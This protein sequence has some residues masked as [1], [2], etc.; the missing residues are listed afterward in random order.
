MVK[1][2]LYFTISC[3]LSF[4]NSFAQEQDS[5]EYVGVS[6][7]EYM[8]V[9]KGNLNEFI[10]NSIRY[11]ELAK[12]D[13]VQGTVVV[14]YWIDT[15]GITIDHKVVRGLRKDLDDEA[16]RVAKLI[17]YEKPAMQRGKPIKVKF[18]VP[19]EFKREENI[20]KTKCKK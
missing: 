13:S 9:F 10:Q 3:F 16:I 7:A 8:P 14:S 11:P 20:K 5:I 1:K 2:F 17:R 18:I 12:F 4:G 6:I 15:T 19:F